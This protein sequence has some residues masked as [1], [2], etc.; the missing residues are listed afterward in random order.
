MPLEQLFGSKSRAKLLRLFLAN[1]GEDGRFYVR[2]LARKLGLQ[3]NSVR[4]EL[5]NLESI[6]M[7]ISEGISGEK[8][9]FYR[10]NKDF[11]L[12]K[13]LKMLFSKSEFFTENKFIKEIKESG[14]IN[15]LILTGGFVGVKDFPTDLLIVGKINRKILAKKISDFEKELGRG[16]NYTFFSPQEYKY[17]KDLTDKFLYGILEGKKIMLINNSGDGQI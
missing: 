9:K 10:L 12:Y 15:L 13:E 4:R 6:G 14:K 7:L 2:E 16:I 3:L 5:F 11:V 8:R 17:R 1:D